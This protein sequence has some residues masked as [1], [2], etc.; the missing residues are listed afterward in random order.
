MNSSFDI[1][2]FEKANKSASLVSLSRKAN[3]NFP[4]KST[5]FIESSPALLFIICILLY[6]YDLIRRLCVFNQVSWCN[7]YTF[8]TFGLEPRVRVSV[9]YIYLKH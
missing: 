3:K 1:I 5:I 6:Y 4:L 7:G 9:K 2:F 8:Q